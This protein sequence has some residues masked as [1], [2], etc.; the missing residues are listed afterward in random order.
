MHQILRRYGCTLPIEVWSFTG[1]LNE[2][3]IRALSENNAVAR[4]CDDSSLMRPL[5]RSSSKDE[6]HYEVKAAVI[7][8]SRFKHILYLDSDNY[9]LRDPSYLFDSDEYK[10]TG[11]IFWPD[12]WKAH[13]E[14]AMW[15]I[16][17]IECE[18]EWSQESGQILVNKERHWRAL[19]LAWYINYKHDFYYPLCFGDAETFRFAFKALKEPYHMIKTWLAGVGIVNL[20]WW[21]AERFNRHTMLQADTTGRWI[22][23]HANMVKFLLSNDIDVALKY[24]GNLWREIKR[25]KA[26]YGDEIYDD[27]IIESFTD[28]VSPTFNKLFNETWFSI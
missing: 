19:N 4:A 24:N 5:Y 16:F 28:V 7:I 12:F 2:N 8:N 27:Y 6:R 11:A 20:N 17:D 15:K 23:V 22:F 14:S 3:Q 26:S 25:V 9:A 1:E 13:T 21:G 10:N 18:N